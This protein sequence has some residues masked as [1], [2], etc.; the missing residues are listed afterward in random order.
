MNKLLINLRKQ[1]DWTQNFFQRPDTVSDWAT[2]GRSLTSKL[3]KAIIPVVEK[4][5]KVFMEE[6]KEISVVI[7]FSVGN[8]LLHF[9][10][11][12]LVVAIVKTSEK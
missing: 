7:H 12:F 6:L 4:D 3:M 8:L 10:A 5:A 9:C 11:I 2:R 1:W